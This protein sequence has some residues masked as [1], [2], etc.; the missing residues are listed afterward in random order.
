MV[1]LTRL[2]NDRTGARYFGK[3]AYLH[4]VELKREIFEAKKRK[5]TDE[6]LGIFAE[7]D[8]DNL[9]AVAKEIGDVPDW[10]AEETPKHEYKRD[11]YR[12][13]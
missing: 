12:E 9:I 13:R 10:N 4:L 5:N 8:V 3:R 2:A 7:L 11:I 1:D 6:Q